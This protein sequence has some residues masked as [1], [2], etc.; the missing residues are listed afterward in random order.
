MLMVELIHNY[1]EPV[2]KAEQMPVCLVL[3]IAWH[4]SCLWS[5]AIVIQVYCM[6]AEMHEWHIPPDARLTSMD[7]ED[8]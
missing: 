2:C 6:Y 5:I 1:Y 4:M 3:F 7:S 8:D